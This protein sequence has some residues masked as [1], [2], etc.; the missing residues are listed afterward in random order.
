VV[1]PGALQR[2]PI[3]IY[4]ELWIRSVLEILFKLAMVPYTFHLSTPEVD[5]DRVL[6]A[7]GQSSLHSEFQAR[8]VIETLSQK[9]KKNEG[10]IL[11]AKTAREDPLPHCPIRSPPAFKQDKRAFNLCCAQGLL[12]CYRAETGAYCKVWEKERQTNKGTSDTGVA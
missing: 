11:H 1:N 6:K 10:S 8:R 3:G 9:K 4:E 2:V 5:K 12:D 7:Q